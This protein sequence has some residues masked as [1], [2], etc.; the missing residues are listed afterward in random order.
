[1]K[2][3]N[4]TVGLRGVFMNAAIAANA[5][6]LGFTGADARCSGLG[7]E[8]EVACGEKDAGSGEAGPYGA[9]G[10]VITSAAFAIM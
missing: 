1:M 7:V 3:T 10:S 4:T 9:G 6:Y 8:S 2:V 5:G